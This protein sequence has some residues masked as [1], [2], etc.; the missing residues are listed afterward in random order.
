MKDSRSR[1]LTKGISW[2]ITGTIDTTV[3]SYFVT[4]NP[5]T[6]LKIGAVEVLTKICLYYVHERIW[7]RIHWGKHNTP[8]TVKE[9]HHRSL[10]KAISWRAT[11]TVDTIII[12][13]FITGHVP[14]A[15]TI[16]GVEV[17]TKILLYYVH[18]RIWS[19]IAW[20]KGVEQTPRPQSD[21]TPQR[22]GE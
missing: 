15:L 20:G 4:G 19:G 11:G 7:A 2:R 16:G 14:A 1:S 3:I 9:G 12:S 22:G 17:I 21:I 8:L 10:A 6:A 18:E 5:F 13:F